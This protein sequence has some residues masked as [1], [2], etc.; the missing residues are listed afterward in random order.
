MRPNW[1]VQTNAADVV[2]I[3]V[4][5]SQLHNAIVKLRN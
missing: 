2:G 5:G 4:K 3:E 1:N